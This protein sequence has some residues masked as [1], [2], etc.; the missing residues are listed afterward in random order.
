MSY[1]KELIKWPLGL[2]GQGAVDGATN[3]VGRVG[4]ETLPLGE[5]P[6]DGQKRILEQGPTYIADDH[7]YH[8]AEKANT[9]EN[10]SMLHATTPPFYV[11]EQVLT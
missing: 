3:E 10:A 5:G 11:G 4:Q 6:V 7:G 9:G 8:E 2:G 1:V